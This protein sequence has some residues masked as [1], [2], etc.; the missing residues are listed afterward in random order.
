MNIARVAAVALAL[1][2]CG[3]GVRFEKD[4]S[5]RI[6][7]PA[8]LA[9]VSTPVHLR[10]TSSLPPGSEF[11]VFLD[12]LPVHPA[13]N[14][15]A[16]AGRR[17]AGVRSCVDMAW[18]NRHFVFVTADGSLDLDALPILGT[19]RGTPDVHTATIVRVDPDWLRLGE[20]AWSVSF[21]VRS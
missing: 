6:V 21:V 9:T 3:S 5:V 12:A 11:A 10:W 18:L 2:A 20:E 15:R 8:S 13:Q 7:T 4:T 17:C 1:T 19:A 14:L 16:L